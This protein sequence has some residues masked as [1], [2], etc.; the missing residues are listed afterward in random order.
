MDGLRGKSRVAL[1]TWF[2]RNCREFPLNP[3]G[4]RFG[5]W[6][7]GRGLW[8]HSLGC[9]REEFCRVVREFVAGD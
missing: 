1:L 2:Y 3:S 8:S 4:S 9:L 5:V 6:V 7:G